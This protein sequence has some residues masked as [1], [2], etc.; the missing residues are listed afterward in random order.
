MLVNK[1]FFKGRQRLFAPQNIFNLL[2]NAETCL[3]HG[4]C[5]PSNHVPRAITL[6]F[7]IVVTASNSS[8]LAVCKAAVHTN[9][10]RVVFMSIFSGWSW[11][12]IVSYCAFWS[13]RS[14]CYATNNDLGVE[15]KKEGNSHVFG[16]IN[17]MHPLEAYRD[18]HFVT[19]VKV[20]GPIHSNSCLFSPI[21]FPSQIII[22]IRY[23]HAQ[24]PVQIL[25]ADAF[26]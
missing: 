22:T 17:L 9:V 14:T 21:K 13:I 4:I 15:T 2:G 5:L 16:K 12:M 24:R 3:I 11:S 18:I 8:Y 19:L 20:A 26:L 10:I 1:D 25:W 7:M 23:T 6:M